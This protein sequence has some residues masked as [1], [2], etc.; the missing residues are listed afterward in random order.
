MDLGK[1]QHLFG[2]L[3]EQKNSRQDPGRG[4]TGGVSGSQRFEGT[5][6]WKGTLKGAK[7]IENHWGFTNKPRLYLVWWSWKTVLVALQGSFE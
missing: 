7:L 4:E 5:A 2:E 6:A 1:E 3:P